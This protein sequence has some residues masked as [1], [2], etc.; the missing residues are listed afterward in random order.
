[1]AFAVNTWDRYSHAAANIWIEADV[2]VDGDGLA[3]YAIF[4]FDN[5]G[6]FSSPPSD[7]PCRDLGL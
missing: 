1:M 6:G 5:S 7:G 3:D 2:D 4:N